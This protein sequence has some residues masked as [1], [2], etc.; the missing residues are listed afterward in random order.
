MK[1]K[2]P[3]FEIKFLFRH[4]SIK[5]EQ[6]LVNI[7]PSK[8]EFAPITPRVDFMLSPYSKKSIVSFKE[9][10]TR[11]LNTPFYI[12]NF[13]PSFQDKKKFILRKELGNIQKLMD[14]I[15]KKFESKFLEYVD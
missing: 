13:T 4:E 14:T 2:S 9:P 8:M 5:W 7:S 12:L 10:D 15:Q 11:A 6:R 1:L 3:V